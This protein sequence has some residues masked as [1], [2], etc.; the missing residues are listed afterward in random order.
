[1]VAPPLELG[2]VK[3]T[4]AVPLPAEAEVIVGAV[5]RSAAMVKV[6]SLVPAEYVVSSA[7]VAR[8]THVPVAEKDSVPVLALTEH[9]VVPALVTA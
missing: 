1:M 6:T 8:T 3:A 2:T 7:A 9:A 5:G 4:V